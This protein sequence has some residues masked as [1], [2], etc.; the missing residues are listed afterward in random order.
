MRTAGVECSKETP[1]HVS[2]ILVGNNQFLVGLP[3]ILMMFTLPKTSVECLTLLFCL[4]V[5]VSFFYQYFHL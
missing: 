1:L 5:V 3:E 2:F 4:A